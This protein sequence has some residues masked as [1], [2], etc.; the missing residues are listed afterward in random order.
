[1]VT[2]YDPQISGRFDSRQGC[3]NVMVTLKRV[4]ARSETTPIDELT[5]LVEE[6]NSQ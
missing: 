3:G 4:S 2:R 5:T 1:M 6:A